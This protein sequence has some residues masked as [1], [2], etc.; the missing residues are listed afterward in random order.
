MLTRQI[1]GDLEGVGF[2]RL[3]NHKMKSEKRFAVL[4]SIRTEIT[5]RKNDC[6]LEMIGFQAISLPTTWSFG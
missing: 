2:S 4:T 3:R 1:G 6:H 5:T